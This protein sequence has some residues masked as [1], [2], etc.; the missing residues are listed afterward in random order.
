M[1]LR[2][3]RIE[4]MLAKVEVT[5]VPPPREWLQVTIDDGDDE[6]EAKEKARW[7]FAP[8]GRTALSA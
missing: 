6:A 2:A 1:K 8:D 7:Q 3:S 4:S 5:L